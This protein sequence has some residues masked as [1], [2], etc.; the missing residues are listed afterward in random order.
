LKRDFQLAW[1]Q[2]GPFGDLAFA[3][4]ALFSASARNRR[5]LG[6]NLHLRPDLQQKRVRSEF[7]KAVGKPSIGLEALS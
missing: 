7:R 5:R 4:K 1:A 2:A 3:E 6:V